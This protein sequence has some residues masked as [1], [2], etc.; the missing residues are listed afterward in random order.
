MDKKPWQ[1]WSQCC[2]APANED[3]TELESDQEQVEDY[4]WYCTECGEPCTVWKEKREMPHE[5]RKE[6]RHSNGTKIDG[7][8][9][10]VPNPFE[11]TMCICI[12]C[13]LQTTRP[14]EHR[15]TCYTDT[16]DPIS[17]LYHL[18]PTQCDDTNSKELK[19]PSTSVK[20]K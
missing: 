4:H 2:T 14:R 19:K 15:E 6:T 13:N 16:F 7:Y 20:K 8:G 5:W 9:K 3:Y 10:Q 1:R 18:I 11:Y 12:H 17:K